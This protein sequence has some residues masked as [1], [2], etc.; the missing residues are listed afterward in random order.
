MQIEL[1]NHEAQHLMNLLDAAVRGA[2]L[3]A[4]A[5]AVPIAAKVEQAMVVERNANEK[6]PVAEKA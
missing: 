5:M 3:T 1:S 4:A 2:G 6:P